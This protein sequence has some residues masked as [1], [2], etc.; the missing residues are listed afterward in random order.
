MSRRGKPAMDERAIT[1]LMAESLAEGLSELRGRAIDVQRI[2]RTPFR[3]SSSF[4]T[5]RL[6]V[7]A[8]GEWMDVFFKD[9]NPLHQLVEAR[10]IRQTALDRSRRELHFYRSILSGAA[11][12]TP[13]LL[14]WRWAPA[15]GLLWLF[16]EDVGP[17]RLSRIGE[18]SLWVDAARW[19]ARLHAVS[20]SL[21]DEALD[22]LPKHGAQRCEDYA[23]KLGARLHLFP[24]EHHR[25]LRY[26]LDLH[27]DLG[28]RLNQVPRGLVHNEY[29]GKNVV[30]R[31]A[32][33]SERIA[34]IDWETAS[35]GPAYIDLVSISTGRWTLDQRL[36]M[37][38]AYF[39]D[40]QHLAQ[41]PPSWRVFCEDVHA[42]AVHH[43]I[44]WLS[45]WSNG[46]DVHIHRWLVELARVL[47]HYGK[48][49]PATG[50]AVA[51]G[52]AE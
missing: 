19:L 43:A 46:D 30:I 15:Q 22:P 34:V 32:S 47:E 28:A 3:G 25:T 8:D 26:A 39:D 2:E 50:A 40:A 1:G 38:R 4:A 21:P 18:F 24:R 6:R 29:F 27:R 52:G 37:W 10:G 5:A 36:A 12:G 14:G 48:S 41:A 20:H 16:L 31:P 23:A 45:W 51:L 33:A 35:I 17:K 42:V 7:L 49:A 44:R 13:A 9:L 11:L